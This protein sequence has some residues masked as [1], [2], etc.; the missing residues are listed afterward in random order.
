MSRNRVVNEN[1]SYSGRTSKYNGTPIQRYVT[2]REPAVKLYR[3]I[4]V[5]LYRNFIYLFI[6]LLQTHYITFSKR[7]NRKKIVKS[8]R[9]TLEITRLLY[10]IQ[11]FA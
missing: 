5:S 1:K 9:E 11:C 7:K 8:C 3:Y 2:S 6:Y 4:E 10:Y